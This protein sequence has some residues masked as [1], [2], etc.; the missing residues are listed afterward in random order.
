[1]ASF[2]CGFAS[3]DLTFS[4]LIPLGICSFNHSTLC[5]ELFGFFFFKKKKHNHILNFLSN[6][7]KW[8]LARN[9]GFNSRLAFN[10]RSST[11]VIVLFNLYLESCNAFLD[12]PVICT[13]IWIAQQ[14]NGYTFWV[15]LL[16]NRR[17][18]I[19]CHL[20]SAFPCP[21]SDW[22]MIPFWGRQALTCSWF[23]VW[24]SSLR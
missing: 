6:V 16:L 19:V 5:W 11:T 10:K 22:Q 4:W 12:A 8:E 23:L 14:A 9:K 18:V 1:M 24:W 20:Q 3:A 21:V 15:F 13:V 2:K 17:S 7:R